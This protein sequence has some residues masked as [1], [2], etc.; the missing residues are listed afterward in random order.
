MP[1]W[2]P[3]S[4]AVS[5][6]HPCRPWLPAA[7]GTD[8]RARVG[9]A[10]AATAGRGSGAAATRPSGAGGPVP[11]AP[12]PL[13]PGGLPQAVALTLGGLCP[14]GAGP[15]RR[16]GE[17]APRCPCLPP[18][19]V[20]RTCASR[21]YENKGYKTAVSENCPRPVL[22][23]GCSPSCPLKTVL[24]LELSGHTSCDT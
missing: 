20:C 10:L 16:A 17:R 1:F 6:A 22:S 21:Y 19:R 5:P 2:R 3:P 23:P 9:S 24:G 15:G 7:S 4:G 18:G 11:A 12:S 13:L 8:R 14:L